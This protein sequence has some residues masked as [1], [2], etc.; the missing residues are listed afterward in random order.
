MHIK[1]IK[2]EYW[3]NVNAKKLEVYVFVLYLID[4]EDFIIIGLED[5]SQKSWPLNGHNFL[6]GK[7]D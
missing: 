3:K 4:C 2:F 7:I 1:N 5:G 6:K